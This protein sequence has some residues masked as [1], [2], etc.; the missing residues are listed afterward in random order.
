MRATPSVESCA[1]FLRAK[2]AAPPAAD[3]IA[4]TTSRDGANFTFLGD[5][6]PWLRPTDD[7]TVGSRNVWLAAPGPITVGDE[8]L[9]FVTRSNFAEG[10]AFP[11]S[12]DAKHG[13]EGVITLGRMRR[14]GLVSLD[15]PY[16]VAEDA[17]QLTTK[18]LTFRG[19]RLLLNLEASGGGSVAIEV[20]SATA[21]PGAVPLLK[22]MPLVHSGVALEV[23]WKDPVRHVWN[24]TAVAALAG[25]PIV[26]RMRLQDCKLYSLRFA[27]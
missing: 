18:P 21:A 14:H 2:S 25:R 19:R 8:E 17:A 23:S 4:L 26:L 11:I 7:G 5:R 15:A 3:D 6:Q 20:H 10:T 9:F 1:V 27:E 22:A 16:S 24:A 13:W 12:E